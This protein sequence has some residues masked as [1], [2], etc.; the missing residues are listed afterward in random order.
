MDY[1][2]DLHKTIGFPNTDVSAPS[3]MMASSVNAALT[4]MH[5]SRDRTIAK[6]EQVNRRLRQIARL[7]PYEQRIVGLQDWG[8]KVGAIEFRRY[9]LVYSLLP[10]ERR[11]SETPFRAR[12]EY[13]AL[14]TTVGAKRYRLEK[15]NHPADL[16]TLAREGYIAKPPMDPYSDA[17]LVYRVTG[18]GFTLYSVGP[19]FVDDGGEPGRD[20]EGRPKVWGVNGDRVFWPVE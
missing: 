13:E 5:A 12:A 11:A 17:P 16:E 15:G 20:D 18:D 6:L 8:E 1:F 2:A 14:V 9:W 10:A 7:S 3:G 19:N 4:M